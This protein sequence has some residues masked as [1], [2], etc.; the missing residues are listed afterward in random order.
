MH[1]GLVLS[2]HAHTTQKL[3]I[4][5]LRSVRT[6]YVL[7][8]ALIDVVIVNENLKEFNLI[9]T[10]TIVIDCGG[11]GI[12]C[13]KIQYYRGNHIKYRMLLMSINSTRYM[14]MYMAAKG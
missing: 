11:R 1:T 9:T 2:A 3:I 7:Y 5:R 14:Y 8:R 6:G 13:G 12:S 10:A 4:Y